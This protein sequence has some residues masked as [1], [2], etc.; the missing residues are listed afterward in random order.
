MEGHVENEFPR[1]RGMG[2]SNMDP[3]PVR[4]MGGV[5][6]VVSTTPFHGPI[7]YYAFSNNQGGQSDEY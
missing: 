3:P 5:T 4:P 7:Q 2:P 1:L 6:Q